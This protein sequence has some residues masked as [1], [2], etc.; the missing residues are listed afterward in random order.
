VLYE[1]TARRRAGLD[2][3]PSAELLADLSLLTPRE[4]EVTRIAATGRRTRDIA[5]EL[6]LS[7]RTVDVHLTLVYR[8][9][10]VVSRTELARLVLDRAAPA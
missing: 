5:A 3:L 9:L 2:D 10:G 1:A 7:P 8:K 6:R 4:L